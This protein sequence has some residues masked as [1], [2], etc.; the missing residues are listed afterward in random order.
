M[1]RQGL[2]AVTWLQTSGEVRALSYQAF[3]MAKMRLDQQLRS[4]KKRG[5]KAPAIVVDVDE[6][7]LDNS[8]Y[9]VNLIR[10]KRSY[11]VGWKEWVTSARARALP[12]SVEFLNYAANRGVT[13]FYITNRKK[14]YFSPTLKNLKDKGFPVT[15]EFLLTRTKSRSKKERREKVLRN[16]EILLLMGDNLGDFH[17]LFE[18]KAKT[19]RNLA[20]DEMK[21]KFGKKFIVLPNPMYGDWEGT[22]YQYNYRKSKKEKYRLIQNSLRPL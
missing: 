4:R 14:Q 18:E 12:G 11:P 17:D 20:V 10:T 21:R 8:P 6:T 19:E 2:M 22:L 13:V 7:V 16:Y 3:N 1:D 9:Q 5:S 15:K